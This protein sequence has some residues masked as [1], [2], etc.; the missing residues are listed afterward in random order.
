MGT[1]MA[2]KASNVSSFSCLSQT[3]QVILFQPFAPIQ[4]FLKDQRHI[5]Q[6]E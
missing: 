2:T 3:L 6:R 1:Y 4:A 5:T